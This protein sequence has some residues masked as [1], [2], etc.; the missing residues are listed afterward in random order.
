VRVVLQK[1]DKFDRRLQSG[2]LMST[3]SLS[4]KVIIELIIFITKKAQGAEKK[5]SEA[6]KNR[7]SNQSSILV[8]SL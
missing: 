3:V 1:S 4:N 7:V 2:W 5:L 8:E 6:S